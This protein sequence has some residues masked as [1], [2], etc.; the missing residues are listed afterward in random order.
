M[1]ESTSTESLSSA[2]KDNRVPAVASL[3]N[4]GKSD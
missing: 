3:E 4:F 2:D 1:T